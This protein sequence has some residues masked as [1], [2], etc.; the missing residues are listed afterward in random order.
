MKTVGYVPGTD[1]IKHGSA[2]E[3]LVWLTECTLAT[4]ED[5]QL[6]SRP[7]RRELARQR[8]LATFGVDAVIFHGDGNE[9]ARVCCTRVQKIVDRYHRT[10]KLVMPW[11]EEYST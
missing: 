7:P 10:S 5:M 11:E 1:D 9:P 2:L 3:D 8:K 6:K 4:V